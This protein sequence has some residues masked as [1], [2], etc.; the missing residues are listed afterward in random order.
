MKD[1]ITIANIA[2][3]RKELADKGMVDTE[4]N[5]FLDLD[6]IP[7]FR[8]GDVTISVVRCMSDECISKLNS[9]DSIEV[10]GKIVDSSADFNNDESRR[11]YEELVGVG[12]FNRPLTYTDE[13][14]VTHEYN[15]PYL[16]GVFA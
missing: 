16:I 2:D 3:L 7:T 4:G 12:E 15:R 6:K 9:I 5:P 13:D 8:S 14:G 10:I 1:F 11:T